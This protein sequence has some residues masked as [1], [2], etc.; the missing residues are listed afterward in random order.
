MD[1]YLST[2]IASLYNLLLRLPIYL[3]YITGIILAI[4]SWNKHPKVSLLT[5]IGLLILIISGLTGTFINMWLPQFIFPRYGNYILGVITTIR[6]I[7][8]SLVVASAWG[9]ILWAIFGW[10]QSVPPS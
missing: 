8:S 2:L 7:I 4:I 9:L 3:I 5:L 10:R 6:G 1:N